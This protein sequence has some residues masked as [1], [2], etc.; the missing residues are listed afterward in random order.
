MSFPYQH[1]LLIGATSGIG[2][3][4]ADRLIA[5][6]A[7][8]T[9]VGRRQDRL[10]AFVQKHGAEKASAVAFDISKTEQIAGFVAD[11]TARFPSI[12]CVFLNAGLQRPYDLSTPEGFALEKFLYE[13][14]VDFT[15]VVLLTHAFLPFLKSKAE[16]GGV[17][18]FLFTGT[19]LAIVP[20]APMPAY[21][22]AKAALNAFVLCLRHQ[23]QKTNVKV[24]EV[25][26]PAVQTEL[27]DYMTPEVGRNVGMPLD[28]FVDQA[29]AG[30]QSGKDQ[31]VVGS[32]LAEDRFHEIVNKRREAFEELAAIFDKLH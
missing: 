22:A 20:A 29:F 4:M 23:L 13:V 12:D 27:H 18:G 2:A 14:Q 6:G 30:L 3:A 28:Q 8:V 9:A 32:I 11:V 31:V 17:G 21:S 5:N 10:D 25:S 26:P 16:N 15:N 24:I 1:F 19:N 7:K